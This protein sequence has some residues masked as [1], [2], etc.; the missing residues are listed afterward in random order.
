MLK[1]VSVSVFDAPQVNNDEEEQQKYDKAAIYLEDLESKV[2]EMP[3]RTHIDALLDISEQSFMSDLEPYEWHCYPGW[4]HAVHG[5]DRVSPLCCVMMSQKDIAKQKEAESSATSGFNRMSPKVGS[6]SSLM[7][8]HCKPNA[9]QPNVKEAA[10]L[11]QQPGPQ[12]QATSPCH[13]VTQKSVPG[14]SEKKWV[15]RETSP[16][17]RQ[18]SQA[19][20]LECRALKVQK[21]TVRHDVTIVPIKNFKFLPPINSLQKDNKGKKTPDAKSHCRLKK[22][23][24]ATR[25]GL[26]A[27]A[28]L[29]R[30]I[31]SPASTDSHQECH[32]SHN[33][34]PNACV[35]LTSRRK[36]SRS[37]K[38]DTLHPT[39]Y[40]L[41]SNMPRGMI[42]SLVPAKSL[43]I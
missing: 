15:A 3:E 13:S 10:S 2:L 34:F 37:P 9:G 25:T 31:S 19:S 32:Q 41:G 38:M 20:P 33:L 23:I 22:G 30:P 40:S 28:K 24:K 1:G 18:T 36:S 43:L 5:W 16:V 26:D 42:Q 14:S 35:S 29:E 39:A 7:E 8:Q 12:E 6:T 11:S 27:T 4:E 17:L 21:H